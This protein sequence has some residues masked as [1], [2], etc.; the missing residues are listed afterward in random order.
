MRAYLIDPAAKTVTPIDH[1]G[2]PADFKVTIGCD[3]LDVVFTDGIDLWIDGEGLFAKG[4]KPNGDPDL[5]DVPLF[6]VGAYLWPLAGKAV[7][8]G[9]DQ[10]G[11]C[12]GCPISLEELRALVRFG[13]TEADHI[14]ARPDGKLF[15]VH[16][17]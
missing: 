4:E 7:V 12:V 9:T 3:W 8:M 10:D 5:T 15:Q 17:C 14:A 6:G 13:L 2:E 16:G 11:E 1:S